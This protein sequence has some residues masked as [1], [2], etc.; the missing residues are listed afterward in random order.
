MESSLTANAQQNSG[1]LAVMANISNL[2]MEGMTVECRLW[3]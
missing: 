1:A 3:L 2:H